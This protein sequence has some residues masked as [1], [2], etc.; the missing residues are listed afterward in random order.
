MKN[1]D[2]LSLLKGFEKSVLQQA[3]FLSRKNSFIYSLNVTKADVSMNF[4]LDDHN[5]ETHIKIV[6]DS[7]SDSF[8][9]AQST[10][11]KCSE[12]KCEHVAVNI[13]AYFARTQRIKI[14]GVLQFV[15]KYVEVGDVDMVVDED[16][17]R[18]VLDYNCI[19]LDGYNKYGYG[20]G[21]LYISQSDI[22]KFFDKTMPAITKGFNKGEMMYAVEYIASTSRCLIGDS[23]NYD[24]KKRIFLLCFSKFILAQQFS[25]DEIHDIFVNVFSSVD[26]KQDKY[27][28]VGLID[29]FVSCDEEVPIREAFV[30]SIKGKDVSIR[31]VND[32]A[33]SSPRLSNITPLSF[34]V[35]Y[36]D[37]IENFAAREWITKERAGRIFAIKEMYEYALW[38]KDADAICRTVSFFVLNDLVSMDG[39]L[40]TTSLDILLSMHPERRDEIAKTVLHIYENQNLTIDDY[41][42]YLKY[43]NVDDLDQIFSKRT[44]K[45]EIVRFHNLYTKHKLD[46]KFK[47]T[48][49]TYREYAYLASAIPD[50]NIEAV[51]KRITSRIEKISKSDTLTHSLGLDLIDC[52]KFLDGRFP[53]LCASY[54]MDKKIETLLSKDSWQEEFLILAN[55]HDAI[56]RL[57]YTR[58]GG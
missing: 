27:S 51:R 6:Y 43:V 22:V 20:Y 47:V 48:M 18:Y 10:C 17:V 29:L 15:D 28:N 1:I 19:F 49:F 2:L 25:R 40:F 45:N 54:L 9:L 39:K 24:D 3:L 32:F 31:L 37:A 53:S 34:Y 12:E 50:E 30:E 14:Q 4:W 8:C 41:M 21:N 38:S 35:L 57:G 42:S 23:Y 46:D 58:Y 26:F 56:G 5:Y 33:S 44:Y 11:T 55:K 13:I 7:P 36:L 16:K 52:L